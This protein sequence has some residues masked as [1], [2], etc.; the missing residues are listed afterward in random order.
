MARR[1]DEIDQPERGQVLPDLALGRFNQQASSNISQG[2]A[3]TRL[4]ENGENRLLPFSQTLLY[5]GVAPFVSARVAI[6]SGCAGF[7]REGW[8]PGVVRY[9]AGALPF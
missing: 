2:Q 5:I 9:V 6:G 8:R 3:S 1:D 4:S 7:T